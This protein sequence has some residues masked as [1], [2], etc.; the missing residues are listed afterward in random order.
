MPRHAR[1][2]IPGA[3]YYVYCRIARDEFVFNDNYEAVE[4]RRATDNNLA[5]WPPN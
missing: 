1:L 5:I 3:T 2:F 4:F